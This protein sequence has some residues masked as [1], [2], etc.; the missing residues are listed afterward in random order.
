MKQLREARPVAPGAP[1]APGTPESPR[2]YSVLL[3]ERAATGARKLL[4]RQRASVALLGPRLGLLIHLGGRL[5]PVQWTAI[6]AG[7]FLPG[8]RT[9]VRPSLLRIRVGQAASHRPRDGDQSGPQ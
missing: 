9:G 7:Q 4:A 5:L 8:Q 2:V 3:I 1:V 6:R